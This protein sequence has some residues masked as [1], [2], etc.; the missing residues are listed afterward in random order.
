MCHDLTDGLFIQDLTD[1]AVFVFYFLNIF[2]FNLVRTTASVWVSSVKT[3]LLYV[4]C[5]I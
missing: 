2:L 3:V 1:P 5:F 4:S